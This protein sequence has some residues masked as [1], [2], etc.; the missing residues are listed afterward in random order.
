M[1]FVLV[2]ELDVKACVPKNC[3]RY[4]CCG[5]S[6]LNTCLV[7]ELKWRLL[8]RHAAACLGEAGVPTLCAVSQAV[9]ILNI[10]KTFYEIQVPLIF[11][12]KFTG[13]NLVLVNIKLVEFHLIRLCSF[14]N[15]YMSNNVKFFKTSCVQFSSKININISHVSMWKH[16]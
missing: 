12:F 5:V 15:I 7:L 4:Q 10:C 1:Y 6:L 11:L 16:W 9:C 8:P 2:D 14:C 3:W 13:I